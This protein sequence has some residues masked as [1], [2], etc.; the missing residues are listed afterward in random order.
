[1][2]LHWQVIMPPGRGLHPWQRTMLRRFN[3]KKH[4]TISQVIKF[5]IM[6]FYFSSCHSTSTH[7]MY[8]FKYHCFNVLQFVSVK[9]VSITHE[10]MSHEVKSMNHRNLLSLSLN[11]RSLWSPFSSIRRGRYPPPPPLLSLSWSLW[12]RWWSLWSSPDGCLEVGRTT[13]M[14]K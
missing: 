12:S 1:M 9:H 14:S 11:S 3:L 8:R 4:Q 13:W 6:L 5:L 10:V 2:R 7:V